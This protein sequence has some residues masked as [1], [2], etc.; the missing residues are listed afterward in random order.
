M[1]NRSA[2]V[3]GVLVVL[4]LLLHTVGWLS[5][6][7]GGLTMVVRPVQKFFSGL[8]L[9]LG[10]GGQAPQVNTESAIRVLNEERSRLL[11]ENA[12]LKED[13]EKLLSAIT[14]QEFLGSRKINGVAATVIGRSPE[15][16]EQILILDRGSETGIA[17][18]QPVTTNEGIFVG[19]IHETGSGRSLVLTPT[20]TQIAVGAEVQNGSRSPGLVSGQHGLTMTMRFIPQGEKIEKGQTVVTSAVD[21]RIPANLVI[22]QVNEVFF[23]TGDLFQSAFVTPPLDF[24]RLRYVTVL[25]PQ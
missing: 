9:T 5:P 23:T 11:V 10:K 14:Q 18:G 17:V 7:E 15:G 8:F 13:R 25:L 3:L 21:E 20:N 24:Q 6:V 1:V 22:G 12:R 16:D 2:T 4:I 19:I